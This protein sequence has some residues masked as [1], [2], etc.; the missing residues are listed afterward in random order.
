MDQHA[1]FRTP[2]LTVKPSGH[3]HGYRV[4][5]ADSGGAP[6]ATCD[7]AGAVRDT[8][9]R[10]LLV[11]PLRWD[12]RGERPTDAAIEVRAADGRPLGTGRVVK[13]GL[14]P[15]A[16]KATVAVLDGQGGEAARLE[17]R[18]QRGEQLTLTAEG[19]QVASIAVAVVKRGF[20]RKGRVYTVALA[21]EMPEALRP[22]ALA[23]AIR[24]DA[25]LNAVA[26]A[27]ARD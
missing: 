13:Y 12:G 10:E 16:R 9:G 3:G 25:L 15:R 1:L 5:V 7:A 18:D 11:A 4:E 8:A 14:G 22:L 6:V 26:S 2:S 23:V 20:L 17:P 19:S 27:A 21:D 24:Y